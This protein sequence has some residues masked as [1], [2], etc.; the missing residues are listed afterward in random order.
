MAQGRVVDTGEQLQGYDGE[1]TQRVLMVKR[2]VTG[3]D[4]G[5]DMPFGR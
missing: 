5:A 4:G 2:L 1:P 3:V